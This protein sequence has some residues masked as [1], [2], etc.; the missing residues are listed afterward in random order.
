MAKS[1]SCYWN[2]LA[3]C[4]NYK[5]LW[6]ESSTV[7]RNTLLDFQRNMR[8]NLKMVLITVVGAVNYIKRRPLKSRLLSALR[9]DL[10]SRTAGFHEKNKIK[11]KYL[12][13]KMWNYNLPRQGTSPKV[14]LYLRWK[15]T[16]L[17]YIF[18]KLIILNL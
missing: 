4:K 2:N 12:R 7:Y 16:Y 13:I 3:D 10:G 5:R 9:E 6:D 14:E 15:L 11:W 1:Y 18:Y 17:F 8:F